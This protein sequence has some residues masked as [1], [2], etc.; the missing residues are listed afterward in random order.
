MFAL[1]L[2]DDIVRVEYERQ[3]R[4]VQQEELAE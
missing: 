1:R 4:L 2:Q 3:Y